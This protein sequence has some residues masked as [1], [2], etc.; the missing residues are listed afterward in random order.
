MAKLVNKRDWKQMRI[1]RGALILVVL[2]LVVTI[3]YLVVGKPLQVWMQEW[4]VLTPHHL[5]HQGRVWTLVTSPLLELQFVSLI[6]TLLMLWM[7]VPTLERFWGTPRFYRFALITSVVGGL[8]GAATGL[9]LGRDA[10]I[11]G[12]SPFIYASVVAFGILYAHQP[13]Q[14]SFYIRMTGRQM[15]Y[16][17]IG[18]LVLFVTI[19]G[20]WE[21]G[22]AFAAAMLTAAVMTSK[23][24]SPGLA[25]KRWRIARA[26]AKL[27]VIEG[28]LKRKPAPKRDDQRFIN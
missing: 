18:F 27:S 28:G 10:E 13:V 8:A 3:G 25:W 4:L 2:Q 24:W 21:Q 19:Q 22:A 11:F 6:L 7:F 5:F 14:F 15:M 20:L 23:R 12:Y 26:R 16:G 1:T 17:F 9:A